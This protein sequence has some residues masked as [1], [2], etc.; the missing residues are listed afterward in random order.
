VKPQSITPRQKRTTWQLNALQRE[1][2]ALHDMK[3]PE[4]WK[5]W[6]HHFPRRPVHP[7][8]KFMTSRLAYRL[9][10][11]TF[12][13]LPQSTRDMLANYGQ[14]FSSI[15]SKTPAKA[16]AMPGATLVREFDGRE[17]RV[18]VLADGRHEYNGQIY[19]SLSAIAKT[20]TGTQWSGPAFFGL[21]SKARV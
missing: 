19:R 3:M 18:Q 11:L 1:V 2:L 13:S 12:G 7:N 20:I 21:K 17:Y 10:E 9:Q 6:D 14:Q 4:L 8:R 16:V 15:K 5:L